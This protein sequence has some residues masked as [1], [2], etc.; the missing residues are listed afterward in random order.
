MEYAITVLREK[1]LDES[2]DLTAAIKN[3]DKHIEEKQRTRLVHLQDAMNLIRN[4]LSGK[5]TYYNNDL[6]KIK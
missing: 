4:H 6:K 5:Q 3:K 2:Y 1:V